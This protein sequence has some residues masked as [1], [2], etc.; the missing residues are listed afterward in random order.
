M[1]YHYHS[2]PLVQHKQRVLAEEGTI[3]QDLLETSRLWQEFRQGSEASLTAIYKQYIYNLYHYGERITSDKE[4]I[5]DSIHDLFVE[6]WRR[7]ESLG[8]ASSVKFY[9]YKGLRRKIIKHLVQKRKLPFDGNVPDNYNF[10]ITFSCESEQITQ[11]ISQ[12]Q[13][14]TLLKAIN[15]LTRRQKEA[16]TLKFYDDLSYEEVADIMKL[17]VRSTYNLVYRALDTLKE[18]ASVAYLL[19]LLVFCH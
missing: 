10:E 15:A 14:A 6:L 7:R 1:I 9:L 17:S 12:K 5:E 13:R 8:Q 3:V 4:L 16:I 19:G 18:H 11:E 2:D